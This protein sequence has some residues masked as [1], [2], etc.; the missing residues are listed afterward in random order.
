M[1]VPAWTNSVVRRFLPRVNSNNH[2][3]FRHSI[4]N[5]NH[6]HSTWTPSRLEIP[7]SARKAR[8]RPSDPS[9]KRTFAPLF[10]IHACHSRI[11]IIINSHPKEEEERSIPAA[12]WSCYGQRSCKSPKYGRPVK[13]LGWSNPFVPIFANE[14]S[15]L[16]PTTIFDAPNMP[17]WN[18]RACSGDGIRRVVVGAAVRPTWRCTTVCRSIR[19]RRPTKADWSSRIFLRTSKK[20]PCCPSCRR[21]EPFGR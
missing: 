1:S 9:P 13:P 11:V 20:I 17:P 8:S 3:H 18:W 2:Y 7:R 19:R 14:G 5:H 6:R 4:N 12:V 15:S 21:T 16:S 10:G